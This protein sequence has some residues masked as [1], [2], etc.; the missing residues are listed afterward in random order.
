MKV[1][2]PVLHYSPVIGGLE[3]WTR[4]IAESLADAF[5]IFIVTGR[6]KRRPRQEVKNGVKIFRTS[7]F[8]LRNLS[9]SSPFYVLTALPFIFFKS[10]LII[11]NSEVHT[12]NILLHCQ[13]FL[14]SLLGYFLSKLTKVPYIVTVQKLEKKSFLRRLVYRN[15]KVCIAASSAIKNYF[16]DIGCKNIEIIPNGVDIKRFDV[17]CSRFEAREKLGLK[18]EFVV[19]TVARLEKVKGIK[20]LIEALSNIE[21]R[22]S[23]FKLIIIG[24]GSERKN[25]KKLVEKLGLK[26]KVRFLGQIPNE[27]IPEYLRAADCFV[28]PSLSEGFGIAILEAQAVGIPA[29]ATNVGGIPDII[30]DGENGILVKPANSEDI[31]RAILKIYRQPE[32]AKKLVEKGKESV[33]KYGWEEIT[34]RVAKIYQQLL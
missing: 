17:R 24:D 25:L 6:V 20:Y 22:T 11:S 13:G 5:S 19:M 12:S 18:D 33:K 2:M 4:N 31:T 14:S 28:L 26:E 3:T 27:R 23:N 29:I 8:S 32:F 1:L 34:G 10:F 21:L 9:Y 30:K 15:A 7:L 16:Q